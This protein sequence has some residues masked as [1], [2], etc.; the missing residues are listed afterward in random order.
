[1]VKYY[2]GKINEFK[3]EIAV[4]GYSLYNIFSSEIVYLNPYN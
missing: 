3:A 4:N 1:M 2:A